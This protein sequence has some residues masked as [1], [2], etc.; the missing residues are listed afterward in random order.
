LPLDA[1][2]DELLRAMH[3]DCIQRK[4]R[5]AERE[6]LRY[7]AG[8]DKRLIGQFYTLLLRTSRRHGQPPQPL[9]WFENLSK[10]MGDRFLAH[11]V[12]RGDLPIAA[13]IT[14]QHK[15]TVTY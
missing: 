4:I 11:L 3:K 6:S 14:L 10:H 1:E 2:P 15:Q 8:R 12:L 13:M 5:R 9:R 7:E